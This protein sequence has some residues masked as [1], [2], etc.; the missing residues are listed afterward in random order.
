MTTFTTT[1]ILT[2][3]KSNCGS[4]MYL[5]VSDGTLRGFANRQLDRPTTLQIREAVRDAL[6]YNRDGVRVT[7]TNRLGFIQVEIDGVAAHVGRAEL[8]DAI[9]A[10]L[11]PEFAI[12]VL[13]DMVRIQVGT[14]AWRARVPMA[15]T[16]LA[17][18]VCQQRGVQLYPE[19]TDRPLTIIGFSTDDDGS[20]MVTFKLADETVTVQTALISKALRQY[21]N[22]S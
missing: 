3:E 18:L 8:L 11:E 7:D 6:R 20:T 17:S 4:T 12:D 19:D 5:A 10:T 14:T 16:L 13:E 22:A 15:R 2:V 21:L 1:L 9:E